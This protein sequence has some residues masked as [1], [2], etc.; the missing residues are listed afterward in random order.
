M[1]PSYWGQLALR[2]CLRLAYNGGA[3]RG[4]RCTIAGTGLNSFGEPRM[5]LT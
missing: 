1:H 3:V 2:N 5:V 4:G